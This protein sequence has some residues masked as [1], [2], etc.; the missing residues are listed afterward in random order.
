MRAPTRRLV[1]TGIVPAPLLARPPPRQEIWPVS[2][3]IAEGGECRHR[4]GGSRGQRA[5]LQRHQRRKQCSTRDL[6][7]GGEKARFAGG[8]P[9]AR[10]GA[11]A[12]TAAH[13][14]SAVCR[15]RSEDASIVRPLAGRRRRRTMFYPT[16]GRKFRLRKMRSGA[17][18]QA[19]LAG[20]GFPPRRHRE[21]PISIKPRTASV[22]VPGSGTLA[23]GVSR[24]IE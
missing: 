6:R 8:K 16:T 19:L 7:R 11:A 15:R 12:P 9:G 22:D 13:R 10:R 17:M 18:W 14:V 3:C 5:H 21:K 4:H 1:G 20:R 2:R 23:T 24:V